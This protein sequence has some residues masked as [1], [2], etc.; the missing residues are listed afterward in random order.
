[1]KQRQAPCV[2]PKDGRGFSIIEVVIALGICSFVIVAILGMFSGGVRTEA[3]ASGELN[4]AN[5]AELIVSEY[6]ANPTSQTNSMNM[7]PLTQT[8]TAWTT[9]NIGWDGA[10]S[11]S[12]N[13][14]YCLRYRVGWT[15]SANTNVAL[16]SLTLSW[17]A[18]A[19]PLNKSVSHYD[20][21]TEIPLQ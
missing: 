12:P 21:V 17:P 2:P 9:Q 6:R 11:S 15:N 13:A 19:G 1:M 16:V 7:K 20:L 10:P 5:L 18:A 3:D 14:P 8:L 4:A